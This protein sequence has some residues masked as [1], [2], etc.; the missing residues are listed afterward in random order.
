M[1]RWLLE[2]AHQANYAYADYSYESVKPGVSHELKTS[3]LNE[4]CT[5]KEDQKDVLFGLSHH[6]NDDDDKL[7]KIKKKLQRNR[8]SFTQR[9]IDI[10]DSG[11]LVDITLSKHNYFKNY[12]LL[13]ERIWTHPLPGRLCAWIAVE[14]I[15][16]ER[17]QNSSVVFES[18]RQMA[19]GRKDAQK[20]RPDEDN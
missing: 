3:E 20:D 14:K 9:Q 15:D 13:L 11:K 10:L 7:G 16:A 17:V 18:T 1:W 19:A 2:A 6:T 12:F 8:T 4:P 5:I